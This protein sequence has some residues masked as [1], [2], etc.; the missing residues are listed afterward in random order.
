MLFVWRDDFLRFIAV[1]SKYRQLW[2]LPVTPAHQLVF[3]RAIAA[4]TG[5]MGILA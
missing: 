2:R 1:E 5:D 3:P 4:M